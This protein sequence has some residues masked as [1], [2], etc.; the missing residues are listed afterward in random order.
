MGSLGAV[1]RWLEERFPGL[2]TAHDVPGAAVAVLV[3][4]EICEHAAGVLNTVT[5]V[6]ATTGSV[7]QLASVTKAW[8][9]TLIMQ[10]VDDG[11]LDLD[12][13]VRRYLPGFRVADEKASATVTP[14]HLLSHTAG[15]DDEP[16]TESAA[17]DGAIGWFVDQHLPTV[18]QL[19]GPG[20][21]FS[22]C[23]AGFTL[24]GRIV[25]VLR[26]KPYRRV[27]R[28][29]LIDPL[30]LEHAATSADE[31]IR[32][33]T[34]VGHQGVGPA[35]AQRPVVRWSL[36]Y[37]NE[38]AGSM[39]AMSARGLLQ[40]ARMHLR[41][42]RAPDDTQVV[43][44]SS[45]RAMWQAQVE[46]P[47]LQP[48]AVHWGLGLH[49]EDHRHSRVVGHDGDNI[50]Q[51]ALLRFL[52]DRDA[53]FVLFCNG[54]NVSGLFRTVVAYLLAELAGLEL[55]PPLAP[56]REPQNVDPHRYV[57]RYRAAEGTCTV[58]ASGPG[59][60]VPELRLTLEPGSSTTEILGA[61]PTRHRIVHYGDDTF[62]T[63]D[64]GSRAHRAFAFIGDD[65]HGRAAFVHH[66]RAI[67]RR[68]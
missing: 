60:S 49:I 37:S 10:L 66:I 4:D 59:G 44:E 35:A 47:P 65:G 13:P 34:S 39:L 62:V 11:E 3:G 5:G 68:P 61:A 32:F 25:E 28:E 20:E 9:A 57:G 1:D 50:G 24:L 63:A 52:P 64:P 55:P 26:G 53:A 48:N 31:A 46:L 22:Y 51:Y 12:L 29:Y 38:P 42:G 19:F 21:N 54:G 7:F 14:R 30:G 6:A 56:P 16:F 40:F 18:G 15:F 45:I 27:L 23:N 8:T 58:T 33:R 41:G 2:V 36:P 43:T 67:P 17:G